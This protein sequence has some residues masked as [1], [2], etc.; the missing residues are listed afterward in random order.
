VKRALVVFALVL[1]GCSKEEPLPPSV[2]VVPPAVPTPA[3]TPTAKPEEEAI[4]VPT[5]EDFEAEAEKSITPK[6][7]DSELDALEKEILGN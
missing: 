7:L 4:D 2:E 5:E 6:S 3:A 1:G